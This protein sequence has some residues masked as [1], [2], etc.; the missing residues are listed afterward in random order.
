MARRIIETFRS[1]NGQYYFTILADNG[2]PIAQSEGYL[3]LRDMMDTLE[4]YFDG[5]DITVRPAG[6]TT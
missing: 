1:E 6:V 3:N 4:K 2:E 5:W